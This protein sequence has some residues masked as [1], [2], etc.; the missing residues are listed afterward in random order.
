MLA[1][2]DVCN[3][4]HI[5]WDKLDNILVANGIAFDRAEQEGKIR[6]IWGR[7]FAHGELKRKFGHTA[8]AG[9]FWWGGKMLRQVVWILPSHTLPFQT[10]GSHDFGKF[11]TICFQFCLPTKIIR[12]PRAVPIWRVD[13]CGVIYVKW[14]YLA[15]KW[16]HVTRKRR[17][18]AER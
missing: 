5:E 9:V 2:L 12:S 18:S 16:S 1:R 3:V 8:G 4:N 15:S 17:R 13:A 7:S 11:L 6:S 10:V 14:N